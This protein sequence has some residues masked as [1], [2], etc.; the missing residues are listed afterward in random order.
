MGDDEDPRRRATDAYV[1]RLVV[2]TGITEAE[3]RELISIL[4]LEWPSLVREAKNLRR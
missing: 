3:A 2:E 1:R 4:G